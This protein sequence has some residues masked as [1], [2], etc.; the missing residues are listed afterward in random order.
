MDRR[1]NKSIVDGRVFVRVGHWTLN[2]FL[3]NQLQLLFELILVIFMIR[4][5]LIRSLC[6]TSKKKIDANAVAL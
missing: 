6:V 5:Y 4:F 3:I 2:S 1:S